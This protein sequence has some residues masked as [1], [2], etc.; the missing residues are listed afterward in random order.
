VV[1]LGD[2]SV[3]VTGSPK[4]N[5]RV[6]IEVNINVNVNVNEQENRT[7]LAAS[8]RLSSS[9]GAAG[10]GIP[11][12]ESTPLV[13][14]QCAPDPGV[15]A[16]LHGPAQTDVNYLTPTADDLCLFDLQKRGAGVPDGEEELG[17]LAQAGSAVAPSHQVRLLEIENRRIHVG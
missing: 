13:V 1:G 14:G 7:S 12:L 10:S 16:G 8:G 4:A 11:A 17:V 5:V 2:T 3:R 6:N 15:L 9:A